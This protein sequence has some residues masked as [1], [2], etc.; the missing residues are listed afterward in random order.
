LHWSF[1]YAYAWALMILSAVLPLLFFRA[2][3]WL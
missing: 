2:K 3:G 1:G